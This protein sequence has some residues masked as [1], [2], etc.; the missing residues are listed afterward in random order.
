MKYFHVFL[1]KGHI[2]KLI[3][4]FQKHGFAIRSLT[5]FWCLVPSWKNSARLSKPFQI[6]AET[7]QDEWRL[8]VYQTLS[9]KHQRM[10]RL[11]VCLWTG[12]DQLS[13][14]NCQHECLLTSFV[15]CINH[16]KS[17][18]I[19]RVQ[20]Q[21]QPLFTQEMLTL[22]CMSNWTPTAKHWRPVFLC[23]DESGRYVWARLLHYMSIN[24]YQT[25]TLTQILGDV[26]LKANFH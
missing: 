18:H 2:H 22:I 19:K 14:Q 15:V 24:Q 23:S 3:V 20:W 11:L 13:M 7:I 12:I 21:I 16:W 6:C 26:S 17:T 1:I 10:P 8:H 25:Q 4:T 9:P 5:Q